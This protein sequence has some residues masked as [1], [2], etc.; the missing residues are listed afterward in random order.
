MRSIVRSA[1]MLPSSMITGL[2]S[3]ACMISG[4]KRR[5][6]ELQTDA[7]NHP[8]QNV[9]SVEVGANKLADGIFE[10]EL[11]GLEATHSSILPML[12]TCP[13]ERHLGHA[14]Y[15]PRESTSY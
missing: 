9:V 6:A 1:H 14:W 13:E 2:Q 5:V 12:S 11:D 8:L 15:V 7:P 10:Y 3:Q 4:N